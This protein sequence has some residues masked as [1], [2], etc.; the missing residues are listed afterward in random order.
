MLSFKDF[1]DEELTDS[2]KKQV[3]KWTPKTR[4]KTLTFSDHAMGGP[5]SERTS[6]PLTAHA[7]GGV[8]PDVKAHLEQNG[9]SVKDYHQG[10]A[11]DKHGR[12][13]K[14]GKALAKTKA[15]QSLINTFANDSSRQAKAHD[16]LHVVVS[17][18]A[19]DVAGMST[20]RNWESCMTMDSGSNREYLKH[21]IKAGTH[22]AYL[23]H[24]DD[25][26]AK[27]PLARIALKPY[28]SKDGSHTVLR[29]ETTTYGTGNDAFSHTVRKFA[30][31]HFPLKEKTAYKPHK[32]LYD[33]TAHAATTGNTRKLYTHTSTVIKN[34]D[35]TLDHF[36]K[37]GDIDE[38]QAVVH[39][40]S[41][42]HRDILAEHSNHHVR[43]AV[44]DYGHS[45][46]MEKMVNDPHP[47][48]RAGV[49]LHGSDQHRA[50]LVNDKEASVRSAVAKYDET[51]HPTLVN[52]RSPD[53]RETVARHSNSR[54]ILGKL[55]A[56]GNSNVAQRA[57][58]SIQYLNHVDKAA[59][60]GKPAPDR[61]A[62][63]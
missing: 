24:K 4:N 55:A 8:H 32:D 23:T 40:G 5:G 61:D 18:N 59:A 31:E 35:E 3:S 12:E 27:N 10:T 62:Y 20:G 37:H 21:D 17:R 47:F 56:D 1:L 13:V 38:A 50:T 26:E 49:A 2:Q 16:S 54:A 6:I 60:H 43:G 34:S 28:T 48:V 33:D 29:P 19:E 53:V 15:P 9:M 11:V 57:K 44:A 51:H 22:V 42:K 63:Q 52:D 25:H 39:A 30:E 58:S 14:I 36:A 45:A 46:H 41:Q 7:V